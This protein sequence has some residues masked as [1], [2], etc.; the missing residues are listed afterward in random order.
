MGFTVWLSPAQNVLYRLETK[1]IPKFKVTDH[2]IQASAF[3]KVICTD[4]IDENIVAC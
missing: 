1:T 3:D 2:M 4:R